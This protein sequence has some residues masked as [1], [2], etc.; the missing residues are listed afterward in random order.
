MPK[1]QISGYSLD[2]RRKQRLLVF[3]VMPIG[4]FRS[5]YF[6]LDFLPVRPVFELPCQFLFLDRLIPHR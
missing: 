4:C 2:F 6:S 3:G 1:F 5:L